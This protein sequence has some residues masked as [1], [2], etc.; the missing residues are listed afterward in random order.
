M[1]AR[2]LL[3][4]DSMRATYLDIIAI[5]QGVLNLEINALAF[6]KN[7]YPKI[8]FNIGKADRVDH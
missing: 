4:P 8:I 5:L 2:A 1:D 7:I 3:K 6:K